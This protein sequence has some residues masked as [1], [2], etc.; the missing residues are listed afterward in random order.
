MKSFFGWIVFILVLAGFATAPAW[1]RLSVKQYQRVMAE[2][3]SV[4]SLRDQKEREC[5][6]D[7]RCAGYNRETGEWIWKPGQQPVQVVQLAPPY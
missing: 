5:E 6:A 4:R 1:V 7:P 2:D 3:A